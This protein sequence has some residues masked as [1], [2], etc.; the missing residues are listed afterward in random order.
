LDSDTIYLWMMRSSW[1]DIRIYTSNVWQVTAIALT[2]IAVVANVTLSATFSLVGSWFAL[3]SLVIITFFVWIVIV[4][5][6]RAIECRVNFIQSVE[7]SLT[8]KMNAARSSKS[9]GKTHLSGNIGGTDYTISML[10]FPKRYVSA[11]FGMLFIASMIFWF[12]ITGLMY[13]TMGFADIFP[14]LFSI[15]IGILVVLVLAFRE[16][17]KP[18][19]IP[20]WEM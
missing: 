13:T 20:E 9:I 14:I 4:W 1:S 18:L 16:A 5:I 2:A 8:G 12:G 10:T 6:V 11:F 7:K 3:L 17:R 15:Q 19:L